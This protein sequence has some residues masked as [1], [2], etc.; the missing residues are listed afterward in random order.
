MA[1]HTLDAVAQ[2]GTS[3]ASKL[4]LHSEGCHKSRQRLPKLVSLVNSTASTI[5]QIHELVQQNDKIF[6]EACM[7]DINSLA[8]KCRAIYV[9]V[10]T[11][12]AKKTQS[13][14]GDKDAKTLSAEQ[15]EELFACLAN[16]SVWRTEA[17]NWLEPRLKICQQEL[18]QVKFELV[19]RYLLG[20]IARLQMETM[21]RSPGAWENENSLRCFAE[22]V[23]ERRVM[24][25]KSYNRRRAAWNKSPSPKAS[26]DD[27]RSVYSASTTSTAVLPPRVSVVDGDSFNEKVKTEIVATEKESSE[28]IVENTIRNKQLD[29]SSRNWFQ[30]LFSFSHKEDWKNEDIMAFVLDMSHANKLITR[31]ELDDKE[32]KANLSK[33]TSSRLWKSR[34]NLVEQYSALDQNVRQD[35]DNAIIVAKRK[36]TREMTLVAM[37]TKKS[38]SQKA[39]DRSS[40]FHYAPDLNV[41]LY[42]KLGAEFEPIYLIDTQE[43]RLELPYTSCA[44]YKMMRDLMTQTNWAPGIAHHIMAGRYDL[45]TQDGLAVMLG[46]WDSVR[47]PGMTLTLKIWPPPVPPGPP[48]PRMYPPPPVG[49]VPPAKKYREEMKEAYHEVVELLGLAEGWMPDQETVKSGLGD[50]LRLWTNAIDPHTEDCSDCA[51]FMMSYSSSSSEYSD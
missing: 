50:L 19:L 41:T 16:M 28:A 22:N 9:G 1:D 42:F 45:C 37:M 32:L 31:L 20:S 27:F 4:N 24:Y 40:G 25:Y 48:R 49:Y 17:W 36:S 35:V 39:A 13:V 44:T 34:P 2:L 38:D 33:L 30:R 8:A 21:I 43:R 14:S 15:V 23:A 29:N 5:R 18:K 46:T 3:L 6:T 26:F 47:R 10:L 51:S 11:L 12:V 7:K